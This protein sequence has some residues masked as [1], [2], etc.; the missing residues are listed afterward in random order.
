MRQGVTL[1]K[2]DTLF[3]IN[4]GLHG[5]QSDIKITAENCCTSF[6]Q[7]ATECSLQE[8]SLG[9]TEINVSSSP[10]IDPFNSLLFFVHMKSQI[11]D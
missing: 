1:H 11:P 3:C 8:T 7:T 10:L 6:Q 2:A 5:V 4:P 9:G